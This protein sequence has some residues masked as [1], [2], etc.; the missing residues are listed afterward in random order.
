MYLH[1]AEEIK[2]QYP[3]G[4]KIVLDRMGL[5][6]RPVGPGSKG[7]VRF[8]DDIGTVHVAFESGR[9]MGLIAGEDVFRIEEEKKIGCMDERFRQRDGFWICPEEGFVEEIYYNPDSVSGG[10]YVRNT[11][12]FPQIIRADAFAKGDARLF[13][14]YLDTVCL[15]QLLYEETAGT[16][17]EDI[18]ENWIDQPDYLGCSKETMDALCA[19]AKAAIKDRPVASRDGLER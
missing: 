3:E 19:A 8:V 15:Q 6:P 18:L 13:F 4:S 1:N 5:D 11:I 14:T 7:T 17:M 2:I 9:Q 10:Q 12:S 16:E